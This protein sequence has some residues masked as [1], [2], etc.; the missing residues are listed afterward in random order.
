MIHSPIEAIAGVH[1]A[2]GRF[3]CWA[4]NKTAIGAIIALSLVGG[5]SGGVPGQSSLAI[6]GV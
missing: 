2:D 6:E 3:F 5:G 1:M 4:G